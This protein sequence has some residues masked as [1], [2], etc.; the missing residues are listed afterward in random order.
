[1]GTGCPS[2]PELVT[3]GSRSPQFTMTSTEVAVGG[4]ARPGVAPEAGRRLAVGGFRLHFSF[5]Y[6]YLQ[7]LRASLRSAA[8]RDCRPAAS[9][10]PALS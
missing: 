4:R 1:M 10:W 6:T 7:A 9:A 5:V 8:E 3:Q 2:W